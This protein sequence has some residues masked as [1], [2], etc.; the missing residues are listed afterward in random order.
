MDVGFGER[1]ALPEEVVDALEAAW[2][3][4]SPTAPM[5]WHRTQT[6]DYNVKKELL[7]Q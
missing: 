3:L 5:Y 4:T 1:R 7:G 2:R 6:Y